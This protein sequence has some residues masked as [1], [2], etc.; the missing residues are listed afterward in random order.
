MTEETVCVGVDVAKNTL[1]IATSN[2]KETRQ[3]NND[4]QGITSAVHYI[5]LSK[6]SKNMIF[7][8]ITGNKMCQQANISTH[9]LACFA[10]FIQLSS[11]FTLI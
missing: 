5:R 8:A 4:H 11:A 2:S 9:R 6:K 3:F 1:D 10:Y 7:L